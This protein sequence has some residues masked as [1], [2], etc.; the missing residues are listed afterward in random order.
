MPPYW[1]RMARRAYLGDDGG[2][3]PPL[4]GLEQFVRSENEENLCDPEDNYPQKNLGLGF[5]QRYPEPVASFLRSGTWRW[6]WI[7]S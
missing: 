2:R 4:Q 7:A 5:A 6:S 1:T 3:R